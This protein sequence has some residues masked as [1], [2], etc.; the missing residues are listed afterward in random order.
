MTTKERLHD[1]VERLPV[2][3]VPVAMRLLEG[4][5]A[6]GDPVLRALLASPPDDESES[7]EERAAVTDARRARAAG[8]R[9]IP[10]AEA[11]RLMF[12]DDDAVA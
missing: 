7:D 2:D 11:E 8:E 3:D 9:P 12:D 10:Q 6:T 5:L 4:L 1:L